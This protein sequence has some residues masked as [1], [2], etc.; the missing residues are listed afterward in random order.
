MLANRLQE[1]ETKKAHA[2][3]PVVRTLA[4][5]LETPT[6][7]YLKLAGEGP[8]FLL[9][10]VSGGEQLA[11]YSFIGIKPRKVYVLKGQ[12]L[13]IHGAGEIELREV[14]DPLAALA[15]ELA[16]MRCEI[17]PGLPRFTGGLAGYL[18]YE[19]MRFFEPSLSLQSHENL[20]DAIFLLAD[21]VIAF[22]H[23]FGRLVLIAIPDSDQEPHTGLPH[24]VFFAPGCPKCCR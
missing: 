21:T 22:D 12:T 9:E 2:I 24:P 4:A 20:P 5:D 19:M 1:A 8:S 10:S 14:E 16:V 15:D 13:T 17:A 23:A 3:S 18:G 11:R 6:S 7:I